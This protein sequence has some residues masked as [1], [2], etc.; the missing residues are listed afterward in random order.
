M[1]EPRLAELPCPYLLLKLRCG[2][3]E[4]P[5]AKGVGREYTTG[6]VSGNMMCIEFGIHCLQG[7]SVTSIVITIGWH[8][9]RMANC[10]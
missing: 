8:H 6:S 7:F 4:Y 9:E 3:E 5:S 2:F 10:K 1:A